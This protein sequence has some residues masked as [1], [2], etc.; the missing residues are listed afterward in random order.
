MFHTSIT[1]NI[2]SDLNQLRRNL[3]TQNIIRCKC[4]YNIK[5]AVNTVNTVTDVLVRV[6]TLSLSGYKY[7]VALDQ[8][9]LTRSPSPRHSVFYFSNDI[10]RFALSSSFSPFRSFGCLSRPISVRNIDIQKF[11]LIVD[12]FYSVLL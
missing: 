2:I 5:Y 10:L 3:S 1:E 6:S 7:G 11:I 9:Q 8:I 4:Q 12:L